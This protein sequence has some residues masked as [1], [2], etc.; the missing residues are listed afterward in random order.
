MKKTTGGAEA[1]EGQKQRNHF[2]YFCYLFHL[3]YSCS[4]LF[5]QMITR[6]KTW[7]LG[8]LSAAPGCTKSL[9]MIIRILSHIYVMNAAFKQTQF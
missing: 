9:T 1:F 4:Y 8:A 6:E 2:D 5:L 7:H 3:L